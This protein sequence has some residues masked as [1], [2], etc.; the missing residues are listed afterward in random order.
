MEKK[1]LF[2]DVACKQYD[3]SWIG[4]SDVKKYFNFEIDRYLSLGPSWMAISDYLGGYLLTKTHNF[5]CIL[6][7]F[8]C[9]T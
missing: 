8:Y 5:Y 6:S 3:T 1:P 7:I 4:W 9:F 2:H